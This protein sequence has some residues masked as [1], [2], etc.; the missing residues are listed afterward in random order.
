[1]TENRKSIKGVVEKKLSGKGSKS[2][3]LAY[4]LVTSEK[5]YLLRKKNENPFEQTSFEQYNGM[6]V[7]CTG[8][9]DEYVFFVDDIQKL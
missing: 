6:Q 4:Y 8:T 3:H 5:Q 2:E 9:I 1:M 7:Q